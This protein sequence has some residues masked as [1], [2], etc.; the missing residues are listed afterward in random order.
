MHVSCHQVNVHV[1]PHIPEFLFS[2]VAKQIVSS[3]AALEYIQSQ[4]NGIAKAAHVI[5]DVPAARAS[6]D[7]FARTLLNLASV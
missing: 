7:T 6:R 2:E 3:E 5:S 1:S 4:P